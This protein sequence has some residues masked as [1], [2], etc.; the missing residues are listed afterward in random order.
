MPIYP[1]AQVSTGIP[2]ANTPSPPSDPRGKQLEGLGLAVEEGALRIK[3]AYEKRQEFIDESMVSERFM[4]ADMQ[5][6]AAAE[7][8]QKP[9]NAL[10]INGRGARKYMEDEIA[11]RQPDWMKG[12]SPR[13]Q[14][15]LQRKLAPKLL[16]YKIGAARIENKS[17]ADLADAQ[18]VRM[19]NEFLDQF[20]RGNAVEVGEDGKM[21][22]SD[23]DGRDSE[24]FKMIAEHI[25]TEV[26]LGHKTIAKGEQEK[27][28]IITKAAY[29]RSRRLVNSESEA[30]LIQYQKLYD[31]EQAKP[32]STFLKNVDPEKR[33]EMNYT[34]HKRL[35]EIR[36][37]NEELSRKQLKQDGETWAGQAIR[38]FNSSDPK[39]RISD[40]NFNLGLDKY[41]G[42]LGHEAVAS[43]IAKKDE[44]AKNGG[45]TDWNVYHDLK[46]SILE[47]EKAISNSE[48]ISKRG[49]ASKEVEELIKLNERIVSE[50]GVE[51][52]AFYKEGKEHLRTKIGG[53][54]VKGMEW[55]MK[56]SERKRYS[57]ALYTF[58]Q[59]ARDVFAKGDQ[60]GIADLPRFARDLADSLKRQPGD[61]GDEGGEPVMQPGDKTP[62]AAPS[63]KDR[64]GRK[65]AFAQ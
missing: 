49:L 11:K 58:N 32:G 21:R 44:A 61:S 20:A 37:R 19:E 25:D 2:T 40:E 26:R 5:L 45:R 8:A 27:E 39:D 38:S 47:G 7:E 64:S 12:L 3:Q 24:Q 1:V 18:Q 10:P 41:Q 42:V 59:H 62:S 60:K 28:G 35:L 23:A 48:I 15:H 13:A 52:T 43:L 53:T 4:D 57:D 30:D 56:E 29:Y 65:P 34:S 55:M 9:E 6:A 31:R 54:I 36:T 14:L 50:P 63:S 17:V 51:K 16:E 46:I 22:I 33:D